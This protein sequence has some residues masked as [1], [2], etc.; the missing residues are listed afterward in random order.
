MQNEVDC[1]TKWIIIIDEDICRRAR[2]RY[3]SLRNQFQLMLI[4]CR[5]WYLIW[6]NL[7]YM[8]ENWISHCE[9]L[10]WGH[11]C[12]S[13]WSCSSPSCPASP[14]SPSEL[15][16]SLFACNPANL[17][18][19]LFG[20]FSEVKEMIEKMSWKN[21]IFQIVILSPAPSPFLQITESIPSNTEVGKCQEHLKFDW[22]SSRRTVVPPQK[23]ITVEN[24]KNISSQKPFWICQ[25]FIELESP[26][27]FLKAYNNF[28]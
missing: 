3:W 22:L 23:C 24:C 17:I 6:G 28:K 26:H 25:Q 2:A 27:S 8:Q 13:C 15:C 21:Q 19:C 14:S 18:L 9:S 20:V 11:I 5:R 12:P 7:Y 4:F 1:W 10:T 16:W